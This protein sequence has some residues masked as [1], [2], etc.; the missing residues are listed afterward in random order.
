M[1]IGTGTAELSELRYRQLVLNE[2]K[3]LQVDRGGE[4]LHRFVDVVIRQALLTCI[5]Q[6]FRKNVALS[7]RS[8]A[9]S[10]RS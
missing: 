10:C 2:V 6:R 5:E 9:T 1:I 3:D 7:L 8:Y 4:I